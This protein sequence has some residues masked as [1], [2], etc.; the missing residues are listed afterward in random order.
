MIIND[1]SANDSGVLFNLGW[2]Y[3]VLIPIDFKYLR[4]PIYMLSSEY[5]INVMNRSDILSNKQASPTNNIRS[6]S[7]VLN[8]TEC[9]T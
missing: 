1:W 7:S 3:P 5:S 2:F 4:N 6:S 9:K 8:A